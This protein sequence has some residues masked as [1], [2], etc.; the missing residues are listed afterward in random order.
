MLSLLALLNIIDSLKAVD[1]DSESLKEQYEK[2]NKSLTQLKT[3]LMQL[4]NSNRGCNVPNLTIGDGFDEVR[5]LY[6]DKLF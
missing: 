6:F 1:K 3:E 5:L 2:L 4:C